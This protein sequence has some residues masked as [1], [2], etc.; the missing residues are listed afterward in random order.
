MSNC[1]D[2]IG[3]S[4][5]AANKLRQLNFIEQGDRTSQKRFE[6]LNRAFPGLHKLVPIST[7]AV[8]DTCG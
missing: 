8:I 2:S 7:D 5:A 6:L 4:H 1:R 3:N